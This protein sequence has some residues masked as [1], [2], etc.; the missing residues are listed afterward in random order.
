MN[1]VALSV[2]AVVVVVLSPSLLELGCCMRDILFSIPHGIEFTDDWDEEQTDP[3]N[4][5]ML[6]DDNPRCFCPDCNA[7]L[8]NFYSNRITMK[9]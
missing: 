8:G 7:D 1:E 5:E 2:L 9:H 4:W 6:K 3:K